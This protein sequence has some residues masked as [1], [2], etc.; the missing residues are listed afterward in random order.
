MHFFPITKLIYHN[1]YLLGELID[2]PSS[3]TTW[4]SEGI[5][6]PINFEKNHMYAYISILKNYQKVGYT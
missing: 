4:F 5:R 6:A 3:G 2:V 1:N